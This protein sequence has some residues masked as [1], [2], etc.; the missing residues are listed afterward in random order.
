METNYFGLGA[1]RLSSLV[2]EQPEAPSLGLKL[3]T[4]SWSS[5][6]AVFSSWFKGI[7][8]PSLLQIDLSV[9]DLE[10][11]I[12]TNISTISLMFYVGEFSVDTK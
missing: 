1:V 6:C 7:C 5:D 8:M 4:L 11:N 12:H 3:R 2:S 9:L 10:V